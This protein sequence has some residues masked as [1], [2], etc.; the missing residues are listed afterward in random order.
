MALNNYKIK[1]SDLHYDNVQAQE[2]RVLRGS[3]AENKFVFD[4]YPDL[5]KN[6]FN[7]LIDHLDDIDIENNDLIAEAWAIGTK[8]DVPVTANDPQYKNNSKYYAEVNIAQYGIVEFT[9]ENGHLIMTKTP[10]T[11]F[12]FDV[13]DRGHLIITGGNNNG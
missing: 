8:N 13:D 2:G 1:P 7:A 6:K 10:S 5:I 9:I 11:P 3:V 12:D 4:A